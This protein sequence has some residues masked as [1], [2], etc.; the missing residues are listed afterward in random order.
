MEG[1]SPQYGNLE[2]Q[3]GRG[4]CHPAPISSNFI[5]ASRGSTGGVSRGAG[6]GQEI[7]FTE[8]LTFPPGTLPKLYRSS[9]GIAVIFLV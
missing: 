3:L 4:G 1:I 2:K 6:Q 5:F 9:P 8:S 7:G